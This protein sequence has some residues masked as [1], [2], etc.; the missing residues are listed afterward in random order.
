MPNQ[1][2]EARGHV[3]GELLFPAALHLRLDRHGLERFDPRHALDQ[4]C[5]VLGATLKFLVQPPPKQR[6]RSGRNRD[7]ERERA[8]DD[9]GQERRVEEHH[10]QEHEGE[11]QVDDQ[12]QR[13]AGEEIADVLQFAHPRHQIADA[14]RLEIGHRQRQQMVKQ[15]RPEFDVDAVG[16]VSEQIGAQHS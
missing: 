2:P 13:R 3:A 1:D 8:E 4:K 5:L 6:R 16:G 15:P 11:E 14:P 7:I 12:G 9:P 10:A